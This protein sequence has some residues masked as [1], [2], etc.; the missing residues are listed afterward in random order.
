MTF[1]VSQETDKLLLEH[2]KMRSDIVMKY[3]S[4]TIWPRVHDVFAKKAGFHSWKEHWRVWENTTRED[5]VNRRVDALTEEHT[6]T[7]EEEKVERK[8]HVKS[9]NAKT[10]KYFSERV[11]PGMGDDSAKSQAFYAWMEQSLHTSFLA[12]EEK[13][14][15]NWEKEEKMLRK[16]D[17]AA[18]QIHLQRRS[19]TIIKYFSERI[20][21]AL[22]EVAHKKEGFGMWK[23]KFV[24]NVFWLHEEEFRQNMA[25]EN[26]RRWGEYKGARQAHINKRTGIVVK[27]MSERVSPA[28][29]DT[30]AMKETFAGWKEEFIHSVYAIHE[31][32]VRKA[33]KEAAKRRKEE[34][35]REKEIYRTTRRNML[36]KY[37][38]EKVNPG[39]HDLAARKEGFGDWKEAYVHFCYLENEVRMREAARRDQEQYQKERQ[40]HVNTR[41][42]MIIKLF[43]EKISPQIY[44]GAAK[45]EGFGV[46][47]ED[48]VHFVYQAHEAET[49]KAEEEDKKRR[50][51]EFQ[52]ERQIHTQT[53]SD[54]II[55]LFAEKISPGVYEV[56]ARKEGFGI[57]KES[58]IHNRYLMQQMGLADQIKEQEGAR[59]KREWE[60]RTET[61]EYRK[62][63]SDMLVKYFSEKVSPEVHDKAA[64]K[65]GFGFWKIQFWHNKFENAEEK[66]R[67]ETHGE[68]EEDYLTLQKQLKEERLLHMK[69]R[70]DVIIKYFSERVCPGVHN[71]AA[72][73]E[74]F[75]FWKEGFLHDRFNRE[76]AKVLR[77]RKE[78][79]EDLARRLKHEQEDH[80]LE[81]KYKGQMIVKYFTE[82]VCPA[83]H[84]VAA[85]KEA[86][87]MWKE[88]FQDETFAKEEEARMKAR[89]LRDEQQRRLL[90][91]REEER[92]LHAKTRSSMVMK[93]FSEKVSPAVHDTAMRKEAFGEWKEEFVH[94][95]HEISKQ[96]RLK[97]QA[98]VHALHTDTRSN[99]LVKYFSEKVAPAVHDLGSKKEGF[100]DWKEQFVTEMMLKRED[101]FCED[102]ELG[103]AKRWKE[104]QA[105]QKL[106]RNVR[107]DMVLK[108]FSEKVSPGIHDVAAKTE[109]FGVW[110]GGYMA[111]SFLFQEKQLKEVMSEKEKREMAEVEKERELHSKMRSDMII[112]YFSDTISPALYDSAAKKEAFNAWSEQFAHVRFLQKEEK[113]KLAMEFKE[114][115]EE[116]R[117]I[118]EEKEREL[119]NQTR[120][121]LIVKYFAETISPAIYDKAAMKEAFNAWNEEFVHVKF[122]E[123]EERL[124]LELVFKQQEEERRRIE[125]DKERELHSKM[126]SEMIVK[127]FSETVSPAVYEGAAKKEGFDC[128]KEGFMHVKFL[129]REEEL[130]LEMVLTQQEEE[131]KRIEEE[132]ERE[133]H[134]KTRSDM[135]VKYFSDRVCP[136]VHDVATKK[137]AFGIWTEQFTHVKFLERE[138]LL[139][140]ELRVK[141]EFEREAEE[142]KR[143]EEQKEREVHN[144]ARSDLIVK[145]FAETVSPA[146]YEKAEK[147]EAFKM[148]TEQF[149]HVRFLEREEKMKEAM[150]RHA[151]LQVFYNSK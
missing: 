120:S 139:Q 143:E 45:K 68:Y 147:K 17:H 65:E 103:N 20:S 40:I 118:E 31:D 27:Y 149:M 76:H 25:A 126:R 48:Y 6:R 123:R 44:E 56:A 130:R 37:F 106:T 55:K 97:E 71:V 137:E 87:V 36:I 52:K 35:K 34:Q 10:L 43:A 53:R 102:L 66:I 142:R 138:V 77:E 140:D 30:A 21:P 41:R 80:D 88:Q 83:V 26:E 14:Q 125:E 144:Q 23:E 99:M 85:R 67:V 3:F 42:D 32:Q 145:Y 86:F 141:L 63:R 94:L 78:S 22:H 92:E 57:W 75:G 2:A 113:L 150:K 60:I 50:K 18:H 49:R 8:L 74:G 91:E 73:K 9:I 101:E 122:L 54:M 16:G 112:K 47:K 79:E 64:K 59:V 114:E 117:R 38:S 107:K 133:M 62:R 98:Y 124:K 119:H 82:K 51:E 128:W 104:Y 24:H 95:T 72:R 105:E 146:L 11:C 129:E 100:G 5:R 58:F 19:Q 13:I 135:I 93:Y 151:K 4:E 33:E 108:Y 15:K 131:R 81:V 121:D 39:L 134:A 116:R 69:T 61:R 1:K 132:K 115:A 29:H 111:E 12:K 89:K 70:S 110:K 96:K 148:W 136:N 28:L 84:D 7:L 109:A 46:W 127:Y 90:L